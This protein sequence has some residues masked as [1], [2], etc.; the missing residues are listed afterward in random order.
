MS[1]IF[2]Y[3]TPVELVLWNAAE[4]KRTVCNAS[5]KERYFP[6]LLVTSK[7]LRSACYEKPIIGAERFRVHPASGFLLEESVFLGTAWL[8]YFTYYM[9][10]LIF[11]IYI[12]LVF[13]CADFYLFFQCL[14]SYRSFVS[15]FVL[16]SN[17]GPRLT[18]SC[19]L[20]FFFLL[21]EVIYCFCTGNTFDTGMS[22]WAALCMTEVSIGSLECPQSGLYFSTTEVGISSATLC[23]V[24]FTFSHK[25]YFTVIMF[26][27]CSFVW[28]TS[29]YLLFEKLFV[30]S[31]VLTKPQHLKLIY[32]R[33]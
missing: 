31:D 24:L 28:Y 16:V 8:C 32:R 1:R 19:F 9:V 26:L 3:T 27:N 11:W 33:Q 10:S 13:H 30:Y 22:W 14:I 18:I 29:H 7:L 2:C 21:F 23:A 4:V 6:S 12:F 25:A 20:H 5:T 15:Y 17:L